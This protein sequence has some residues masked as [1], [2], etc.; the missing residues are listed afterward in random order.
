[1]GDGRF[2]ALAAALCFALAA[3][4]QQRGQFRLARD[5]QPVHGVKDIVRLF[6]V[7]VW[8]VG[9]GVLLARYV[10]QGAALDVGKI[11]VVQPC[12]SR[13]SCSHFRSGT[14]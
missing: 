13:P 9:T 8:L 7:P 3:A 2:L 14:G 11:V 6:V 12:W 5:G 4:L 1:M 10:L